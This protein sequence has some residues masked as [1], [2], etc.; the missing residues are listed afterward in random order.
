MAISERE[1]GIRFA[2]P[3]TD[4]RRNAI[5]ERISA[6]AHELALLIHDLLPGCREE[7]EAV[8]QL[9]GVVHW[10]HSGIDRRLVL[11]GEYRATLP[12]VPAPAAPPPA[13]RLDFDTVIT[14]HG[15]GTWAPAGEGPA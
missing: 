12:G 5:K 2:P 9:E 1:I 11:P 8:L 13:E 14:A 15:D 3:K 4:D 6:Q 7:S 10:A